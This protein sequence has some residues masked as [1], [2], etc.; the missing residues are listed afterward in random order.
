M[1]HSLSERVLSLILYQVWSTLTIDRPLHERKSIVPWPLPVVCY[2]HLRE[3]GKNEW[4]NPL[5]TIIYNSRISLSLSTYIC[6]LYMY[7][8][9]FANLCGL[10]KGTDINRN[11]VSRRDNLPIIKWSCI[12]QV[13]IFLIQWVLLRWYNYDSSNTLH[14]RN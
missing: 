14:Y 5:R 12:I 2:S 1:H 3:N 6:I 13:P 9:E 7:K 4:R 8:A 10:L 11:T